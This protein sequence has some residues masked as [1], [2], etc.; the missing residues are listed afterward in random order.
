MQFSHAN[1]RK[2]ERMRCTTSPKN[3]WIIENIGCTTFQGIEETLGRQNEQHKE[4]VP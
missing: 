1:G 4:C 3:G 2:N